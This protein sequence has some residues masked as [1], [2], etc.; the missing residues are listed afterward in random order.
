VAGAAA[1]GSGPGPAHP[2]FCMLYPEGGRPSIPPELLLLASP[3]VK[4]L[5]SSEHFSV[6][7]TLLRAWASY[8]SLA[9][10]ASSDGE[11][12]LVCRSGGTGSYLSYLGHCL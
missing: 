5:L 1:G 8:S 9:R 6:D 3:E 12:R 2:T 11:A 7:S 4:P 10:I